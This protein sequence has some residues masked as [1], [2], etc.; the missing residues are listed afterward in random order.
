MNVLV[1]DDDGLTRLLLTSALSKLGHNVREAENGR[2]ALDLWEEQHHHLVISDWMMPDIDGLE[3]CRKIRAKS[4]SD[5]TYVIL[6]TARSG[7]ENYL[8]AMEA[9]ADDFVSK[10]FEKDQLAARVRVAQR[11]IELHEN[12]RA[13]NRDLEGHVQE[14]TADLEKALQAKSELLSR[15]SHELRTPLNHILGFGQLLAMDALT[16]DQTESVREILTSGGHLL[17]LVN[18]ILEVAESPSNDLSFLTTSTARQKTLRPR[19]PPLILNEDCPAL[20]VP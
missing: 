6:L 17:Q 8:A 10:P 4:G 5:F 2:T 11:I 3:L 9:G 13:A 18:R 12:L 14:R 1:A 16:G 20:K 19:P 7:K 15:V